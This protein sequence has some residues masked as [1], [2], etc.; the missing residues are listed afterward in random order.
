MVSC[1]STGKKLRLVRE[2]LVAVHFVPMATCISEKITVLTELPRTARM[3]LRTVQAGSTMI[4]WVPFRLP[5]DPAPSGQLADSW[6]DLVCDVVPA[7]VHKG[8]LALYC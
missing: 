7:C 5:K 2:F 3:E 1:D 6:R 8:W 4:S